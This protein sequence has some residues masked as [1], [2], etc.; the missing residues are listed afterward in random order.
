[1]PTKFGFEIVKDEQA[2]CRTSYDRA[3]SN[4]LSESYRTYL[5]YTAEHLLEAI[6]ERGHEYLVPKRKQTSEKAVANWMDTHDIKTTVNDWAFYLGDHEWHQT[7][8]LYLSNQVGTGPIEEDHERYSV[9][10]V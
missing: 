9:H 5:F 1:M 2:P 4:Q 7:Y 10:V 8:F 6:V 3:W